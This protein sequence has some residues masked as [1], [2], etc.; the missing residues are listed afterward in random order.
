M[1][2]TGLIITKTGTTVKQFTGMRL[3]VLK[4]I[5]CDLASFDRMPTREAIKLSMDR[6][7]MRYNVKIIEDVYRDLEELGYATTV[8]KHSRVPFSTEKGR[9]F[10]K[11]MFPGLT[12]RG[13]N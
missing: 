3:R 1:N 10:L 11:S 2:P 12:F 13:D 5:A 9:K 7:N 8:G 6:P 4:E